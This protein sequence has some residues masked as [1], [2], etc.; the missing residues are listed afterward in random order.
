MLRALVEE[1]SEVR[2][3]ISR[4]EHLTCVPDTLSYQHHW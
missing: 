3:A 1:S 2:T 4:Y